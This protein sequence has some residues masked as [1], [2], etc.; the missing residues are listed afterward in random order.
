MKILLFY[1]H[2]ILFSFSSFGLKPA[3]SWKINLNNSD[4][5]FVVGKFNFFTEDGRLLVYFLFLLDD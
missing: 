2:A 4:K 1:F 5:K 3:V